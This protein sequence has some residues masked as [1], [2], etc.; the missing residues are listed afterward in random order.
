[1]NAS[2]L[3][4]RSLLRNGVGS[5]ELK[6]C[7][8]SEMCT[9]ISA[10][11]GGKPAWPALGAIG[12]RI[13]PRSD[14]ATRLTMRRRARRTEIRLG[15]GL[16]V[17]N[18]EIDCSV[19]S[20]SPWLTS[21]SENPLPSEYSGPIRRLTSRSLRVA[22]TSGGTWLALAEGRRD[23]VV[24]SP[25]CSRR[26]AMNIALLMCGLL[27]L[28]GDPQML[29]DTRAIVEFQRAA[30][31]YAFMHRRIERRQPPLEV[32]ADVDAIRRSIASMAE[33]MRV[34]RPNAREGDLFAAP[35]R[36]I[37]RARIVKAM[38]LHDLNGAALSA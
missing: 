18:R 37:L 10:H 16:S 35:V 26:I 12:R 3:G 9:S 31:D 13:L 6:I 1:M 34:A 30:D 14:Q 17:A 24:M 27:M 15:F 25:G 11:P 38:R 21:V 19:S 8:S 7:W 23:T 20:V 2:A 32:T 28:D 4:S 36:P 33:A 29:P 22:P 5:S